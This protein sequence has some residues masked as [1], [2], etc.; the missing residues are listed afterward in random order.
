MIIQSSTL[1]MNSQRGFSSNRVSAKKES[2][3]SNQGVWQKSI[4]DNYRKNMFESY[5]DGERNDKKEEIADTNSESGYAKKQENLMKSMMSNRTQKVRSLHQKTEMAS[6]RSQVFDYLFRLLFGE[7]SDVYKQL[8]NQYESNATLPFQEEGG[9]MEFYESYEEYEET[10]FTT[11]G[12][13]KTADGRE[14]SF[15]INVH[16]SRSYKEYFGFSASYGA[17]YLCTDPLVINTGSSV[18]SV[19]DMN[20]YF[21]LNC[22]GKKEKIS[23]LGPGSGF[24]ALDRNGDGKIND[25]SELF[26][27]KSGDG[28]ADLALFDLDRNGWIDEADEVFHKLSIWYADGSEEPRRVPLKEAGIGAICLQNT[29]TNFALTN[30]ANRTNAYIRNSGIFLYE[31]GAVGTVQHVDMVNKA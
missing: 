13:V 20:F 21:D 1:Q 8:K 5:T 9:E 28:F 25:G 30:G 7:E 4:F 15:D 11:T 23:T 16:M 29:A 22:D 3:W 24:L 31:N 18:A 27:T 6:I 14:M 12:M 2:A 17:E 10:Q 26:G 19:K